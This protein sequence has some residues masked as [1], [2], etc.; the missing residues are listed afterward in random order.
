M[1]SSRSIRFKI[2]ALLVIPLLSLAAL[3]IFG[4]AVTTRESANLLSVS[5]LYDNIGRPAEDL[6]IA[7]QHEHVLS[8][9]YLGAR[10][11]RNRDALIEQRQRT[12]EYRERMRRLALGPDAQQA[13]STPAMRTGFAD[14]MAA[15]DRLDAT[16]SAVDVGS[17]DLPAL[18]REFAKFSDAMQRLVT[19]MSVVNDVSIQQ[20]TRGLIAM[21]YSKEFLTRERALASGA[22]IAGR[23]MHPTERRLFARLV[24]TRRFLF[25]QALTELPAGVREPF[26]TL[27][28]SGSFHRLTAMEDA[29]LAGPGLEYSHEQLRSIT[30]EV[31]GSYQR[32]LT[33]AGETLVAAARPMA[34]GSFVRAGIAG[35]LGLLA[36]VTSLI[37]AVRVGSG[38][39][40]E[41]RELRNS[42]TDLAGVRL[43]RLIDRLRRGEQVDADAEAPPITVRS[44]TTEVRDVGTA[45]GTVQRTAVHSAAEQ[46]RVRD[47]SGKVLRNLARRNQTLLQA[48]LKVLDG[49]QRSV[50][51]PDILRELF[52]VDHLTTR[53]RRHAE[54]LVV[55]AGGNPGR[56]YR[57]DVAAIDALRAAVAEVEDYTR[58][59][60]L[61]M[62][63]V[64]IARDAA[65]DVIHLCAE[66]VENATRFSPAAT[67]VTVRGELVARGLAVE[68]EDRGLGLTDEEQWA[69]NAKL[70]SPPEFDPTETD[71]LGLHVVARLAAR[72][73][74]R[75]ELRASAYGGTTAI[76]LLPD[77]LT[78]VHRADTTRPPIRAL[79]PVPTPDARTSVPARLPAPDPGAETSDPTPLPD[80]ETQAS[81][82]AHLPG[83]APKPG[84]AAPDPSSPSES[85]DSP[86]SSGSAGSTGSPG[87]GLPRR[88]RKKSPAAQPQWER[89][90]TP[91]E[92]SPEEARALLSS[93]QS[94]WRRG[95]AAGEQ[96]GEEV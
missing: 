93:L 82:P 57:D 44:T 38:L 49:L 50:E 94:G 87:G 92:R 67:D 34:V 75:V 39:S 91:E 29:L 30:D 96:D 63:N 21:A 16:R 68:I 41:L 15:M 42:A 17:V 47:T 52:R 10:S 33:Q 40:R 3:W 37:V 58:V 9:E 55:L 95:R 2:T 90:G 19:S 53:M 31:D 77:S 84:D 78:T 76:V 83:K 88:V 14:A 32:T 25:D 5:A 13:L 20:R 66:L 85:S 61:P 59:R 27:A 12:D 74:I 43:P 26:A 56:T 45:F 73:D 86:D 64:T 1:A 62:P 4:A 70:S 24:T 23:T 60:V 89:P 79:T 28:A 7:L 71:R 80:P 54:G 72:H 48:Q 11:Q 6:T 46:A 81:G 65:A 8:A 35:V 22:L 36:V 18:T 51:D 69:L